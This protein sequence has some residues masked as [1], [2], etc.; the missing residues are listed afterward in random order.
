MLWGPKGPQVTGVSTFGQK[1]ADSVYSLIAEE[2][3]SREAAVYFFE[4]RQAAGRPQQSRLH[5][6]AL[7]SIY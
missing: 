5:V 6:A 4:G 3:C 1:V 7:G 2:P